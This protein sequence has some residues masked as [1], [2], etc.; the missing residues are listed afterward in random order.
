ML[1][2]SNT[3]LSFSDSRVFFICTI[4]PR[5]HQM[6]FSSLIIKFRPILN[7]IP[8]YCHF[9]EQ[10]QIGR[11]QFSTESLAPV[12]RKYRRSCKQSAFLERIVGIFEH[13]ALRHL[14]SF[15]S[16]YSWKY[17]NADAIF[18][19]SIFVVGE[20]SPSSNRLRCHKIVHWFGH[21]YF[22]D[23]QHCDNLNKSIL[24]S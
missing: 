10:L 6:G 3:V 14:L 24:R 9:E 21:L 1:Y 7:R 8:E 5:C 2:N 13:V 20:I 18:A 22:F 17:F 16:A 4:L 11:L 15:G 19:S 23:P 12:A